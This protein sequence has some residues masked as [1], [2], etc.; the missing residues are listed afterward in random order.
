MKLFSLLT[1]PSKVLPILKQNF[2]SSS[3]DYKRFSFEY[4][5][6]FEEL[7]WEYFPWNNRLDSDNSNSLWF[8]NAV[9]TRIPSPRWRAFQYIISIE[10]VWP[11]PLLYIESYSNWLKGSVW[12]ID[13]YWSYFHFADYIPESITRLYNFLDSKY[14][15]SVSWIRCTRVDVAL[16]FT[17]PFP[18]MAQ[19]WITPSENARKKN[20]NWKKRTV[21]WYNPINNQFQSVSFLSK[22]NSWYWIRIYNKIEDIQWKKESWYTNL[23]PHLTRI[24]FE[25]YPPYSS[26]KS[27]ADMLSLT[28]SRVFWYEIV[29]FWLVFRPDLWFKVENAYDYF[30]R[31]A[32]SKWITIDFLLQELQNFHLTLNT[33]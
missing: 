27:S 22:H 15:D 25:F 6:D 8:S 9:L 19:S 1:I 2:V 14:L 13:F 7:L 20:W 5:T 17:F 18:D 29:P 28:A 24:E 30:C 26:A 32:K 33:K 23:P 4:R 16:D 12:R 21:N 11:V 3:I 31:Y 10:G